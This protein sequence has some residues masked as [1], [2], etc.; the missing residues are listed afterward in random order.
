MDA[1]NEIVPR[2]YVLRTTKIFFILT[3]TRIRMKFAKFSNFNQ[4]SK[5]S[6]VDARRVNTNNAVFV[7]VLPKILSLTRNL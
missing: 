1:M 7:S 4:F 6:K 3:A 5:F 2:D